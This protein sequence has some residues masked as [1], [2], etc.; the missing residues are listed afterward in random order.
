MASSVRASNYEVNG[1][2]PPTGTLPAPMKQ[3]VVV[4]TDASPI[5]EQRLLKF[6]AWMGVPAKLAD[7]SIA[8]CRDRSLFGG[9]LA[10]TADTLAAT[11]EK[12]AELAAL[13]NILENH[14]TELLLLNCNNP[15]GHQKSLS[16]LAEGRLSGISLHG[17]N[18]KTSVFEFSSNERQ[19]TRQFSG[20]SFS[21]DGDLAIPAFELSAPVRTIVH[22]NGRPNFIRFERG[23]CQIF[24]AGSGIPDIDD[25]PARGD[26]IHAYRHEIIPLLIFFRYGFGK[27]CWHS[28]E[29]TARLI[30]DDP[31]LKERYGLLQYSEL[32]Q[33][34]RAHRYGTSVAFIPWNYRRT[35]RRMASSLLSKGNN[36]S[37]CVHG[38]D[39]T[40]K[41]FAADD[42]VRL[43]CIGRLAL[44]RM[45]R[46]QERTGLPFEEVMVFPQGRFSKAAIAALRANNYLAAVNS[47]CFPTDS[48]GQLK[49]ADF[50]R[51]AVMRFDGFP[52]FPRHYPRDLVD[53]AFALFLGRPALI[54]EHH[55]FFSDKCQR[56][57]EFVGRLH[58]IEPNLAW[59]N[60]S[61]QLMRSCIMRHASP[62]CIEVQFFTPRF[63]LRNPT[64]HRCRF[65]LTKFEP[66]PSA[67]RAVL[68]DGQSMPFSMAADSLHLEFEADPG[69]QRE[70]AIVDHPRPIAPTV[71]FGMSYKA[72]VLLRRSLS[73]F[74]DSTL[75]RHPQMLTVAN[76]IARAFKVT[77]H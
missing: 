30:I 76:H 10:M 75:A 77:G 54:V 38:C 11:Y 6:A 61:S 25:I 1:L 60:L 21:L 20:L 3:L 64:A 18:G 62:G 52:I 67:I 16:W 47:N 74:R 51:P 22:V 28:P 37:I 23:Q 2:Q 58:E 24:L 31:L 17:G 57:E 29:P 68:V 27:S 42:E 69:E 71:S 15:A 14:C 72:R 12:P 39:H 65:R 50:L 48:P 49:I 32:L 43:H 8:Q 44:Q 73:E 41:E 9:C 26:G 66:D 35:S 56:I 59:P 55:A 13:A 45:Q 40:N 7:T 5:I 33:S 34:M 19:L 36:F 4:S 70:I 63:Q 46:H 53:F